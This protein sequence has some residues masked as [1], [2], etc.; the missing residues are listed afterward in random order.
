[1]NNFRINLLRRS[2]HRTLIS[3]IEFPSK[4]IEHIRLENM[5][6]TYSHTLNRSVVTSAHHQFGMHANTPSCKLHW[7]R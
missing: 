2:L 1:M 4:F 3:I 7:L 5:L 6:C